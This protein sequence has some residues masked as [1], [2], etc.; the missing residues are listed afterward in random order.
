M[1]SHPFESSQ[2]QFQQNDG[3]MNNLTTQQPEADDVPMMDAGLLAENESPKVARDASFDPMPINAQP[4]PTPFFTLSPSEQNNFEPWLGSNAY[5][6]NPPPLSTREVPPKLKAAMRP[7]GPVR[8]TF[9]FSPQGKSKPLQ[10]QNNGTPLRRAKEGEF[11]VRKPPSYSTVNK[12][13][14]TR[15]LMN[16]PFFD[17][18]NIYKPLSSNSLGTN[19]SAM[20]GLTTFGRSVY[21]RPYRYGKSTPSMFEKAISSQRANTS[22]DSSL[23]SFDSQKSTE[24]GKANSFD[25]LTSVSTNQSSFSQKRSGD[26]E[27]QNSSAQHSTPNGSSGLFSKHRRRSSIDEFGSPV[28]PAAVSDD[29]SPFARGYYSRKRSIDIEAQ[30]N[31]SQPSTETGS[32][33][34]SSKY[35]RLSADGLGIPSGNMNPSAAGLAQPV[36]PPS[37]SRRVFTTSTPSKS[38][39]PTKSLSSNSNLMAVDIPLCNGRDTQ[40]NTRESKGHMP[41]C[42]PTPPSV[43]V[44]PVTASS[45]YAKSDEDIIME[46][47]MMS[48]ALV[49]PFPVLPHNS[50]LPQS[51]SSEGANAMD[52]DQDQIE[53]MIPVPDAQ[54]PVAAWHT[55]YASV[56]ASLQ[57]VFQNRIVQNMADAFKGALAYAGFIGQNVWN[58]FEPRGRRGRHE[59]PVRRTSPNARNSPARAILRTLSPEQQQR[60]R[61]NQWRRDRGYPIVEE[62]PFPEVALDT[63]QMSA[64][65]IAVPQPENVHHLHHHIGQV[66][67]PATARTAEPVAMSDTTSILEVHGYHASGQVLEPVTAATTEPSMESIA[68]SVLEGIDHHPSERMDAPITTAKDKA[69]TTKSATKS[70]TTSIL[71]KP[72]PPEPMQ[73][74]GP[75]ASASGVHKPKPKSTRIGPL[76]KYTEARLLQTRHGRGNLL[77]AVDEALK[78]GDWEKFRRTTAE[79]EKS[80]DRFLTRPAHSERPTA[81][82]VPVDNADAKPPSKKKSVSL[83]SVRFR[84][85]LVTP[86]PGQP[87]QVLMTELAPHL[88]PPPP[89]SEQSKR[90]KAAGEAPVAQ[91]ENVPPTVVTSVEPV[92]DIPT[93][94]H[95]ET[96]D[97]APL[98]DPWNRPADFPLGRPVSAVSLFYPVARPLPPGRTESIY[99]DEFKEIEEQKKLDEG[100]T[101]IRPEGTAVRPLSEKWESR[102]EEAM[103]LPPNRKIATTLSG[104]PLTKKDLETCFTPL[105]WLNDEVINSYLALI[106]DYLR[107]THGNAGRHDKP[108]FHAFNSF[109]FSNLRDKGYE[110]V[111]RWASRAKIGGDTLLNVDTVFVPV[112]NNSHWTLIV[113]K[114]ADRTLENFD[115]LGSLSRRHIAIIKTWLRGEL[116]EKFDEDEWTV[117]PSVSP[118][119]D[120]G[121][122]CG[123]FLLSTAKAV[124]LDIEPM[125]YGANNTTLLRKKIV[126][127]LMNGGFEGDFNPVDEAGETLL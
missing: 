89:V 61:A 99:A 74:P 43:P 118:Q 15:G 34:M 51:P 64:S 55:Y 96:V 2:Q 47:A 36:R 92:D 79:I 67:E 27:A 10:A 104:D 52:T 25:S 12:G 77:R 57:R 28:G 60:I 49:P 68:D 120:N 54:A 110:S 30:H 71:K 97:V 90:P 108:R 109:F 72:P 106:I 126:A 9:R 32:P 84:E 105:K 94:E 6:A 29:L 5:L 37:P 123:V 111:R 50:T 82:V 14:N 20:T 45:P 69:V 31:H 102:V 18:Y 113:V 56:Y 114:P 38:L 85:P 103:R 70:S 80:P 115:S 88:R 8:P 124:A 101:R 119:Q 48:G 1:F 16:K 125:A 4:Q 98:A 95:I 42:W 59:R 122:D 22:R 100:P 66:I 53:H 112:H 11:D 86:P 3:T 117:L 65:P 93:N 44:S 87:R 33:G 63:P 46:G 39:T 78:T 13:L 58:H 19:R 26:I 7:I 81:T 17:N 107:R 24:D 121:S 91:K 62:Y 41:G 75:M 76:S 73:L 21:D 116:G 83:K 40:L 35:R 23:S 127:E